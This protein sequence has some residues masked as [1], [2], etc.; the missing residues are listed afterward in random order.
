MARRVLLVTLIVV[1]TASEL[2]ASQLI[3]NGSFETGDFSGWTL[4]GNPGITVTNFS[5]RSGN[6]DVDFYDFSPDSIL[7]QSVATV[8]ATFYTLDYWLQNLG[9]PT[10]DFAAQWNGVDVPGSVINNNGPF[11]YTEFSFNVLAASATST[12]TFRGYQSQAAFLLDDITLTGAAAATPEPSTLMLL[13]TGLAACLG[14][15]IL[16]RRRT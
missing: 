8:P 9:G 10:N 3:V 6:F 12:V 1:V 4:S 16:R 7:S 11:G 15:N 13:G 5:P 14:C 2:Q